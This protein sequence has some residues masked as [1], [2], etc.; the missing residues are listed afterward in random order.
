MFC[1]ARSPTALREKKFG[2]LCVLLSEQM[3]M[4][5]LDSGSRTRDASAAA[6]ARARGRTKGEVRSCRESLILLEDVG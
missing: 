2:A 3:A 6:A 1:P 4:Q 5:V